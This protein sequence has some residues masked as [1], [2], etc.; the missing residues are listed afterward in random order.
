MMR[1]RT[2]E[3]VMTTDVVS[4]WSGTGFKELVDLMAGRGV[5]GVPVVDSGNVVVGVVSEADLLVKESEQEPKGIHAA[6]RLMHRRRERATATASLARDL[7]TSPAVTV[8]PDVSI[9]H[10]A[11]MMQE[12]GVKRLPVVDPEGH[13]VGI[14]SRRDLLSV[15]LRTDD[16]IAEEIRREV[17]RRALLTEPSA[18][19]VSVHEGHVGL[20][21]EVERRSTA[22][23]AEALVARVDGVVTV[24][25]RLT[26]QW[27]DTGLSMPEGMSVDITHEPEKR[28]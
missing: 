22:S 4:A 19:R 1:R 28:P 15:F 13:L 21:G 10:A 24:H 23:V 11:R 3:D 12:R 2:V 27:D 26:H 17:V 18:V 9:V 7:M 8:T 6:L 14:V 16:D 5:S 25:N 20:D